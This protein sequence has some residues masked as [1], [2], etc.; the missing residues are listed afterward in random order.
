[1]SF[2]GG[3]HCCFVLT[4]GESPTVEVLRRIKEHMGGSYKIVVWYDTRG[5][6]DGEFLKKLF[7]FTD[8]VVVLSRNHGIT[9][10]LGWALLYLPYDYVWFFNGDTGLTKDTFKL[11]GEG[12]SLTEKVAEVACA[13]KNGEKERYWINRSEDLPDQLE[14]YDNRS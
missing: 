14:V 5:Q 13:R 7:E 3:S 10:A 4:V 1:V 11:I 9:P 12:F 8:D 6:L 2:E